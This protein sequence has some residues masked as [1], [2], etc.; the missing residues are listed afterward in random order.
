M[1]ND[2]I[3]ATASIDKSAHIIENRSLSFIATASI[4]ESIQGAHD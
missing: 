4:D 3:I 2:C 1:Y